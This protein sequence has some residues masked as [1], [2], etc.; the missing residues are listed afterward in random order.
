MSFEEM[1]SIL[2]GILLSQQQIQSTVDRAAQVAD[3]NGRAIQAMIDNAATDRLQN[4]ERMQQVQSTIDRAAQVADSNG[5]AIQAMLDQAVTDRLLQE[6]RT[7]QHEER[8]RQHEERMLRLEAMSEGLINLCTSIDEDRPTI[9]RLLN[10][11]N[12]KLD[13]LLDRLPPQA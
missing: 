8:T 9:L 3:S 12:N 11:N 1:Q 13:I 5:R 2:Q 7:Q 6:E 10:S 4:E